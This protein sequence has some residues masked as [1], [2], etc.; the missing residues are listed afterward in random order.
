[1]T[2][3]HNWRYSDGKNGSAPHDDGGPG[4]GRHVVDVHCSK[5]KKHGV[6]IYTFEGLEEEESE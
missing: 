6:E 3:E 4:D 5:C 1:M 2:C